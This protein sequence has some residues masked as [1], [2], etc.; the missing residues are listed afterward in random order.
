MSEIQTIIELIEQGRSNSDHK[1]GQ[2][3]I[4]EAVAMLRKMQEDS[5]L[6]SGQRWELSQILECGPLYKDI[7]KAVKGLKFQQL[8]HGEE[9][10]RVGMMFRLSKVWEELGYQDPEVEKQ[11]WIVE[12]EF[13]FQELHGLCEEI[14]LVDYDKEN[15]RNAVHSLSSFVLELI[16]RSEQS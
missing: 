3:Q 13:A 16:Y 14:G 7:E 9:M 1:N 15:I 4:N 2:Q 8:T 6:H 10:G 5:H 11:K 12:K